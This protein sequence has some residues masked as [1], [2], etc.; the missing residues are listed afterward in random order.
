LLVVVNDPHL[1]NILVHAYAFQVNQ[2]I[3]ETMASKDALVR[4]DA[5]FNQESESI[6][7]RMPG[8]KILYVP[9]YDYEV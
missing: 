6:V 5:V 7:V 3:E 2:H 9:I 1:L 8:H 4:L